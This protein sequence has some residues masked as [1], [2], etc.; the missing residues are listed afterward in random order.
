MSQWTFCSS[1]LEP[2][3]LRRPTMI[4]CFSATLIVLVCSTASHGEERNV[5]NLYF[6]NNYR[7]VEAKVILYHR[8]SPDRVY[9]TWTFRPSDKAHLSTDGRRIK[10]RG[11][12]RIRIKFSNGRTRKHRISNVGAHRSDGKWYVYASN[13]DKGRPPKVRL[14]ISASRGSARWTID[15]NGVVTSYITYTVGSGSGS[16]KYSTG[17]IVEFADGNV[18]TASATKTVGR[19]LVG[20]RRGTDTNQSHN[21]LNVNKLNSIRRVYVKYSTDSSGPN[22]IREWINEARQW[23]REGEEIY[24]ELKDNELVQ[25]AVKIYAGT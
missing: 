19:P 13:V 18:Y 17:L 25:D 10:V 11:D 7:N 16:K 6:R 5:G 23:A 2:S 12:W 14:P 4:V 24:K 21:A 22:T 20:S 15:A 9:G 3:S 8:N 1:P